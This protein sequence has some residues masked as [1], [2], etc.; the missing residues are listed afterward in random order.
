MSNSSFEQRLLAELR[1]I[2]AERPA[3]GTP[4]RLAPTPLPIARLR[5]PRLLL[6]GGAIA[7][8][9]AAVALAFAGGANVVPA[10]AITNNPD[11]TITVTIRQLVGIDGANAELA[12]RGVPARAIPLR[13]LVY[14]CANGHELGG[15]SAPYASTSFA[16]TGDAVTIDPRRLPAGDRILLGAEVQ[17]NGDSQ[18]ESTVV[19]GNTPRCFSAAFARSLPDTPLEINHT[20]TT[21]RT[22]PP[23]H[24]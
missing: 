10:Y 7:A 2:V 4:A 23:P 15:P 3:P 20:F 18:I 9:V 8:V 5:R 24:P 11:G 16:P 13:L 19:R 12:R 14:G 17:A 22:P 6:G 21:T 1:Q